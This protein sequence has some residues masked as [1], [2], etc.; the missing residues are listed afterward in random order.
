M[1]ASDAPTQWSPPALHLNGRLRQP[2]PRRGRGSAAAPRARPSL[3]RASPGRFTTRQLPDDPGE[4]ARQHRCRDAVGDAV[5]ADRLGDAGHLEV[6]QRAGDLG[7][8]VR[9]VSGR[10]LRW[11]APPGHRRRRRRRSRRRP[12]RRRVRR[13]APRPGSPARSGSRRSADRSR[14]RRHRPPPGWT[15]RRPAPARSQLAQSPDLP[16]VLVSTRTSVMTAPLSTALTMSTTVSA[17]TETAVSASISTPVR[18]AGA[19]GRADLDRVVGDASG[20]PSTPEIDSGWHS[21]ISV[22]VC[23]APMIPAIRATASASPLGTPSPRSSATTC[24]DTSTRPDAVAVRAVTSLPDTS[25]MRA[26]PDSSTWVSRPDRTSDIRTP[27]RASA[28]ATCSPAATAV[29]SSGTTIS[30]LDDARS[31]IRWEPCPPT[32]VT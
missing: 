25:T 24:G 17:A 15:R 11:S 22:G 18:S 2:D 29:T 26:A 9:R 16:P 12:A 31:P 6:E 27:R 21:G 14:P 28:P 23:L 20:R 10:C 19:D 30:A 5:R 13:P 32:G 3:R 7:G 8:A 1:V 4:T